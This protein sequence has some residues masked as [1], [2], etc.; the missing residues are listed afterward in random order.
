MKG[1]STKS[2]KSLQ[3][4]S[5]CV[6]ADNSGA[7]EAYIITVFRHKTKKRMHPSAGIADLVNVVVSKGKMDIKKKISRAV[8]VR[9]KKEFRRAD[10]SRLKFEDNAI[11]LVDEKGLPKGSE[12]K[13]AI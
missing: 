1:M 9:T 4:L 11:V 6:C 8:I 5:T 12:I 13:G 7:K 3:Q 10:V 2:A